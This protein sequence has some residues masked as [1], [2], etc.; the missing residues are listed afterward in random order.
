[1]D[2]LIGKVKVQQWE[3]LTVSIKIDDRSLLHE[4]INKYGILGWEFCQWLP[5]KKDHCVYIF[6]RPLP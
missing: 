4:T 1:M 2:E 6:K 5:T 3:G